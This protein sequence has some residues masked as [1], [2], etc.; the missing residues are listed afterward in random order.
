VSW[1]FPVLT[2]ISWPGYYS[3]YHFILEHQEE[4]F[5]AFAYLPALKIVFDDIQDSLSLATK[6]DS[7]S[8]LLFRSQLRP[9]QWGPV[10]FPPQE[11]MDVVPFEIL[12]DVEAHFELE[13]TQLGLR[14]SLGVIAVDRALGD[15]G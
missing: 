8:K 12:R 11:C 5:Q 7:R 9:F 1:Y 10:P 3:L 4:L 2:C 13:Q 14:R 6:F 15:L